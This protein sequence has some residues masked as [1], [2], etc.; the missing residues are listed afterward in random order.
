M[1]ESSQL[2]NISQIA[3]FL[4]VELSM[5]NNLKQ[6]PRLYYVLENKEWI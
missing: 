5:N 2:K 6:Q 4:Q 3:S 1:V